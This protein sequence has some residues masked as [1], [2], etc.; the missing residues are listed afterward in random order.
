MACTKG[1]AKGKAG[2]EYSVNSNGEL[3]TGLG[4]KDSSQVRQLSNYCSTKDSEGDVKDR[5]R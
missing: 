3:P 2:N 1:L 4:G 5:Q